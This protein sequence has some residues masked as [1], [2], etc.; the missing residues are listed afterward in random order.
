M[1]ELITAAAHRVDRTANEVAKDEALEELADETANQIVPYRAGY[2]SED[3][4][5]IALNYYLSGFPPSSDFGGLV[6]PLRLRVF[7]TL[8]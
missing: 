7:A 6:S 8:R 4:Q 1:V 2:E 5:R 3:R